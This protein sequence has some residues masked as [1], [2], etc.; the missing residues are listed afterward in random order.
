[1]P[2]AVDHLPHRPAPARQT[3][4]GGPGRVA[5]ATAVA[6]TM[7]YPGSLTSSAAAMTM[8]QPS[9]GA[10]PSPGTIFVANG[11]GDAFAASGTGP[12]S[13]T[14]YRPGAHGNARPETVL[15]V[16]VH[17]PSGVAFDSS[18]DL[19]VANEAPGTVV[20]FGRSSLTGPSPV[21]S[22]TIKVLHNP[23]EL[24]FD[25]AGDLWVDFRQANMVVELA[26]AGLARSG[27]PVP[28]VSLRVNINDCGVAFDSAG[29]LWEGSDDDWLSE[30]TSAELARSGS[31]RPQVTVSSGTLAAPCRP[32]FDGLGD[33]WVGSYDGSN[34]V[35]FYKG[36]LAK[37]G[38]QAPRVVN[39][40][41]SLSR[42]GE[43]A[44]SAAG[45]SGCRTPKPTRSS[46]LPSANW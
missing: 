46:S 36:Q 44:V 24:A 23:F 34:A 39:D 17:S 31:Q 15:T 42:P 12:G 9:S 28:K 40:S 43:P 37:S 32:T 38:R 11:G 22:V 19:W 3:R 27:S 2:F 20:E 18:G 5:C 35:E 41:T 33:M 25:P 29:N 45:D 26:K 6:G 14:M 8:S 21:P 10:R 16:G 7:V 1:M 13:V 30:W 4:K